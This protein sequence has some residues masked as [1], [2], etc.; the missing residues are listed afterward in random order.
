MLAPV[1][2]CAIATISQ[3]ASDMHEFNRCFGVEHDCSRART[4]YPGVLCLLA[5]NNMYN[6]M[7]YNNEHVC[8]FHPKSLCKLLLNLWLGKFSPC[9]ETNN[10]TC[11]EGGAKLRQVKRKKK[12][13]E[14]AQR[15]IKRPSCDHQPRR[16]AK[17]L[18]LLRLLFCVVLGKWMFVRHATK[19]KR[20]CTVYTIRIT[21]NLGK[22][23]LKDVHTHN[24]YK[25]NKCDYKR[26]SM[27]RRRASSS[28]NEDILPLFHLFIRFFSVIVVVVVVDV[29]VVCDCICGAKRWF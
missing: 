4:Q 28:R 29:V 20:H 16:V 15:E 8:P 17:L 10:A 6:Q 13:K 24:T 22:Y 7:E 19:W 9:E 14:D 21:A 25:Y 18:L 23:K 12:R 3:I 11:I 2:L 5:N 27:N 26:H 1:A